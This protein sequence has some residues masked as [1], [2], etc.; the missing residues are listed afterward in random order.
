ML[1]EKAEQVLDRKT[2]Q[3]HPAQVLQRHVLWTRPEQ[4][5]GTFVTRGAI[6]FQELDAQDASGE[7]GQA[8]EV[9]ITP[10][11]YSHL[12]FAQVEF[13]AGI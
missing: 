3:I 11:S 1:L 10:G 2:P 6:F 13:F 7:A 8:F 12:L 9:Q 5:D 4:P